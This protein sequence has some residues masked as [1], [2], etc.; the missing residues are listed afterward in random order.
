VSNRN[1]QTPGPN[2]A[3]PVRRRSELLRLARNHSQ[4]TVADLASKFGV[5]P[6]T[7]RRDLD[8]LAERGLLERTH[9]GA[10]PAGMVTQ[11]S[12]VDQ[13]I[14]AH[15]P[16]KHRIA[17]AAAALIRDGETLIVNGGSTTLAF[18][19]ELGG[20][21]DITIVT[22]NLLLPAVVPLAAV[23]DLYVLGGQYRF[24]SQ[25]TIGAVG[26]ATVPGISADTAVIGVGGITVSGLSTTLLVEAEMIRAMIESARRTIV[27]ADASKF[28]HSSF[29]QIVSLENVEI[30]VTDEPPP[31]EVGQALA[32]SQ[33][34]TVLTPS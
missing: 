3:L 11:D 1:S 30:L 10:V 13:R 18:A 33:V 5:S 34:E 27:L 23:R 29:V 19:S 2:G 16:A 32:E 22:N 15:K 28:G 24:E 31:D 9:G 7:I 14:V 25:V 8:L 6:D 21:R 20:R 17:R 26:F 4:V 12:P